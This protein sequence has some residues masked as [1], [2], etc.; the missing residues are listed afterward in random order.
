M[1]A[2]EIQSRDTTFS[3]IL[4][5]FHLDGFIDEIIHVNSTQ[6]TNMKL[7]KSRTEACLLR[8]K[9]NLI[10]ME[11]D[12][13]NRD[14]SNE[15]GF[16]LLNQSTPKIVSNRESSSGRRKESGNRKKRRLRNKEKRNKSK[17]KSHFNYH[18][19]ET[20]IELPVNIQRC[21]YESQGKHFVYLELL[22]E[23]GMED[24][25]SYDRNVSWFGNES[26]VLLSSHVNK[27]G[28]ALLRLPNT[29][30]PLGTGVITS[31]CKMTVSQHERICSTANLATFEIVCDNILKHSDV[32]HSTLSHM[33]RS[34]SLCRFVLKTVKSY[35]DTSAS[36]V[37]SQDIACTSKFLK[38]VN[39]FSNANYQIRPLALFP[40]EK[41]IAGK[42]RHLN[43]GGHMN[44]KEKELN[45]IDLEPD[46]KIMKISVIP[47]DPVPHD[48]YQVKLDYACAT[49]QTVIKMT[50]SGSDF[51]SNHVVC[52]GITQC[53][54]CILHAAGA[55][56]AVVDQVIINVTDLSRK[57]ELSREMI[58]VF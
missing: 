51:Y 10:N 13:C 1:Y 33:S 15:T 34:L 21:G 9:G 19:F 45:I 3:Q 55:P 28:V 16:S 23:D 52:E 44:I 29:T 20:F 46:F 58:V 56:N 11:V 7:K 8:L 5:L 35:C 4:V 30:I 14:S 24:Q 53:S 37:L 48:I 40:D 2:I 32:N 42:E 27:D 26:I 50:V 54:C 6:N 17:T 57:Y 36:R 43:L 38:T 22:K 12:I 39:I 41:I 18:G 47:T 49:D 31:K 25:S